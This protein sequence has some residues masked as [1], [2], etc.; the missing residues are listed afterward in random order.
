MNFSEKHHSTQLKSLNHNVEY[1]ENQNTTK[2]EYKDSNLNRNSHSKLI[3]LTNLQ[4]EKFE[5]SNNIQNVKKDIS[6]P[7][8]SNLLKLPKDQFYLFIINPL[9]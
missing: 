3:K 9:K 4:S 7:Q 8:N 1:F 2:D 6:S 5:T